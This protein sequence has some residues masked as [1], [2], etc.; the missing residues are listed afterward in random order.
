MEKYRLI[1]HTKDKG[2]HSTSWESPYAA[3]EALAADTAVDEEF[4]YTEAECIEANTGKRQW[5][6]QV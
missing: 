5:I 2:V 6:L 1:V 4:G 3:L